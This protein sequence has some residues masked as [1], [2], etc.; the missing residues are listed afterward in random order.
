M[1]LAPVS[2]AAAMLCGLVIVP[3]VSLLTR[4]TAFS[5]EH[6]DAIF[7]DGKAATETAR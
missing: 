5:A 7:G 1:S 3:V 4:K 2:G 6:L